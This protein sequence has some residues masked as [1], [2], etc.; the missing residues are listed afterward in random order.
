MLGELHP[1]SLVAA[2]GATTV[3]ATGRRTGRTGVGIVGCAGCPVG[4]YDR[5][6]SARGF[7][8]DQGY[9]DSRGCSA[10]CH[11]LGLLDWPVNVIT[12]SE[13]SAKVTRPVRTGRFTLACSRSSAAYDAAPRHADAR[14]ISVHTEVREGIS[15]KAHL[16]SRPAIVQWTRRQLISSPGAFL[17]CIL[18][19]PGLIPAM[20]SQGS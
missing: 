20:S 4:G 7:P 15:H 11:R 17:R 8:S 18:S 9:Q 5:D 13:P 10:K 6:W 1:P 3:S 12:V 19:G 16:A 2:V 14:P